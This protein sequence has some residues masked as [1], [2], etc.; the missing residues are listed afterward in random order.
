[1]CQAAGNT[2]Q[3]TCCGKVPWNL[4]YAGHASH[5]PP[6]Y[7]RNGPICQVIEH[8]IRISAKHY[9]IY[10]GATLAQG[11]TQTL[12]IECNTRL[13]GRHP[14]THQQ[15]IFGFAHVISP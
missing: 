11:R 5:S 8:C 14:G 1:M 4:Q 7:H 15:Y 9:L 2:L 13:L 6:K 3:S 10:P 12:K